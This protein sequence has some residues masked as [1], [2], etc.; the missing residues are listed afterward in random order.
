MNYGSGKNWVQCKFATK[1]MPRTYWRSDWEP[2]RCDGRI[3]FKSE[4]GHKTQSTPRRPAQ[5]TS[6]VALYP[7]PSGLRRDE[8]P[9]PAAQRFR[10]DRRGAPETAV[11]RP[12]QA[13]RSRPQEQESPVC[14]GQAPTRSRS[15]GGRADHSTAAGRMQSSDSSFVQSLRRA[16]RNGQPVPEGAHENRGPGG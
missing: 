1:K 12:Q 14:A 15:V 16:P 11:I 10:C 9:D 2:W 13:F 8:S 7:E 6:R 5:T 3:D 4:G